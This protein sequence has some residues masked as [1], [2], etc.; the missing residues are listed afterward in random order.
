[1]K[2]GVQPERQSRGPFQKTSSD[3]SKKDFPTRKNEFV[4]E[5]KPL[6]GASQGIQSFHIDGSTTAISRQTKTFKREDMNK[7]GRVE[8]LSM[9]TITSTI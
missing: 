2:R 6:K 7:G 9:K 5:K 4:V 3:R 8:G 1:M